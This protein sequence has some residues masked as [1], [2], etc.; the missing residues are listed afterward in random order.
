MNVKFQFVTWQSILLF[1]KKNLYKEYSRFQISKLTESQKREVMI[2]I[3]KS[4]EHLFYE[5]KAVPCSSLCGYTGREKKDNI[6]I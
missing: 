2:M 6:V 3:D 4:D 5:T 1:F